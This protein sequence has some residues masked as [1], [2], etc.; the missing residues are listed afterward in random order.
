M[1]TNVSFWIEVEQKVLHKME[2]RE[3]TEVKGPWVAVVSQSDE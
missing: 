3:Q 2:K 1:I